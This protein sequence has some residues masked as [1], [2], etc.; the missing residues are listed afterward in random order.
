[1]KKYLLI[2]ISIFFVA[3]FAT[4]AIAQTNQ[5]SGANPSIAKFAYSQLYY[6]YYWDSFKDN[7]HEYWA[8][9]VSPELKKAIAGVDRIS[10]ALNLMGSEGWE[11]VT[12]YNESINL[13]TQ[14]AYFFKKQIR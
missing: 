12:T 8:N 2:A 1:M 11:L 13:G 7:K 5:K 3:A 14:Y 9:E 4:Y 6:N 10:T